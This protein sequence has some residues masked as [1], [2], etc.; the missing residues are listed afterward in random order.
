MFLWIKYPSVIVKGSV[1][2]V[3]SDAGKV[4]QPTSDVFGVRYSISAGLLYH[5][6]RGPI[7][8]NL[9]FLIFYFTSLSFIL[10]SGLMFFSFSF[11]K[12]N[13]FCLKMFEP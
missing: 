1:E 2:Q 13:R 11:S 8:N 6:Y 4:Q 10:C 5:V 3:T 12:W 9:F 7:M